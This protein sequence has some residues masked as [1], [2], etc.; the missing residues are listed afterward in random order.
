MLNHRAALF[1]PFRLFPFERGE[2]V[3]ELS[4][5]NLLRPTLAGSKS[6][7]IRQVILGDVGQL[8]TPSNTSSYG[9][10]FVPE[11]PSHRPGKP[12]TL[13][14]SCPVKW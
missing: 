8:L 7:V 3:S 10:V 12:K 13:K 2:A 14:I 4:P 5:V 1:H 9:A 11:L 6:L